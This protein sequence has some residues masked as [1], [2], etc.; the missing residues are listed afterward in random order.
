MKRIIYIFI[1]IANCIVAQD[2]HFSQFDKTPLVINPALTGSCLGQH[3]FG[4]NYREQGSFFTKGYVSSS[5]FYD[6]KYVL[7]PTKRKGYLGLGLLLINDRAGDSKMGITQVGISFAYF[8]ELIEKNIFSLGFQGGFGQRSVDYSELRWDSQYNNYS[9][10]QYLAPE[11]AVREDTYTYPDISAGFTWQYKNEEKLR[12]I[13]GLSIHHINSIK[14]R[15]LDVSK[16]ILDRKILVHGEVDYNIRNTGVNIIPSLL[17]ERQG[18]LQE[19]LFGGLVKLQISEINNTKKKIENYVCFGIYNRIQDS[20]IF[21][22]VAG[23]RNTKVGFNYD[24]NSSALSRANNHRGAVEVSAIV[25]V[26]YK[27]RRRGGA[28]L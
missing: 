22:I 19:L 27:K 21:T 5:A 7:N 16:E 8:M 24:F 17:Y 23:S 1:F 18:K 3:R 6:G 26:P 4:L 15:Y 20:F 13:A 25:N 14:L 11:Y 2:V 28:M 9:Y 12:T 10:N